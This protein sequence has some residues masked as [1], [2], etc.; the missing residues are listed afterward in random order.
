MHTVKIT[1][2][3]CLLLAVCFLV[4][5]WLG[6]TIGVVAKCFLV[7]WLIGTLL[8]LWIGVSRAGYSI[9]DELP[10]ALLIYAVPAIVAIIFWW[11]S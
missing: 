5:R 7:L 6:S 10:I 9:R 1:F 2:A 11:K 4:G 3:G 8:N